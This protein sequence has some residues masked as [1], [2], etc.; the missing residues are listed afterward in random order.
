MDLVL[1]QAYP[2]YEIKVVKSSNW[3]LQ[4]KRLDEKKP[5]NMV[6]IYLKI[7]LLGALYGVRHKNS[8]ATETYPVFT[9][10]MMFFPEIPWI[11]HLF[12]KKYPVN[13]DKFLHQKSSFL[14]YH[15]P[16]TCVKRQLNPSDGTRTFEEINLP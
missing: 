5:E 11:L 3:L 13:S 6:G 2:L 14:F 12:S 15:Y 1:R 7:N 9:V 4:Q 10:L 8:E 16:K